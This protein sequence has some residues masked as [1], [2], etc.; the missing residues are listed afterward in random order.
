MYQQMIGYITEIL[1]IILAN[2]STFDYITKRIN[3]NRI[4]MTRR[5]DKIYRLYKSLI[6]PEALPTT[7]QLY[8]KIKTIID[9]KIK[10]IDLPEDEKQCY[11]EALKELN[12][13]MYDVEEGIFNYK[14]NDIDKLISD[15]TTRS[16]NFLASY[17]MSKINSTTD[18]VQRSKY[19]QQLKELKENRLKK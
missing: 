12:T 11:E 7:K 18:E 15:F 8:E 5:Q 1:K 2:P 3:I 13:Y 14:S 10:S 4:L 6:N 17:W 16:Y 9:A 19:R